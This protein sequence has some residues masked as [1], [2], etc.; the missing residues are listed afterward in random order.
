LA[1]GKRAL[2]LQSRLQP[3]GCRRRRRRS[4]VGMMPIA[5]ARR[6]RCYRSDTDRNS[7]AGVRRLARSA[8]TWCLSTPATTRAR[9]S[10][11]QLW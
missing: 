11:K 7:A 4:R 3:Q 1:L 6:E 8:S 9:S 2:G 10:S 5:P